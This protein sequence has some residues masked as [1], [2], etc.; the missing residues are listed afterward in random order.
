[1]AFLNIR[2]LS[3]GDRIVFP[4]SSFEFV[5]HHAIYAGNGFFYENKGWDKVRLT[6]YSHLLSGVSKIT[7]IQRFSGNER[8]RRAALE[9][10]E[11]M[12]GESYDPITFNCEHFANYVQFGQFRSKQVEST[13]VGLA[14][15]LIIFGATKTLR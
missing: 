10:A 13:F 1:M 6:H 11:S 12:S 7:S 3:P 9:R 14:I 2:H 8:Q 5:Q 15:G 4:K